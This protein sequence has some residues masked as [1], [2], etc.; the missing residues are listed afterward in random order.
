MGCDGFSRMRS[1]NV[2]VQL[3]QLPRQ[4]D[5]PSSL[6]CSPSVNQDKVL[7]LDVSKLPQSVLE[8]INVRVWPGTPGQKPNADEPTRL[9]SPRRDRPCRRRAAEQRDELAATDH[10]I[11][12]SARASSVAGTSRPSALAV[13]RLIAISYLVG[14][15]TARFA[16]FSPLRMRSI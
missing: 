15:C 16:G 11:T 2:H 14:A 9:L 1:K 8:S 10:S 7:A 13:L 5:K 4:I 6:C 3:E 12:S